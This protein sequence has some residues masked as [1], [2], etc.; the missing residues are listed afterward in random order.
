MKML[1]SALLLLLALAA[2]PLAAQPKLAP[3]PPEAQQAIQSALQ[4]AQGGDLAGAIALL[5]PLRKPGAHPAVLSLLGSLYLEAG[6]SREALALL[7]PIA[8]T[9]AAGPLILHNAARAALAEGQTDLAKKYLRHAVR[10]A[11]GSPAARD[12]GLLLG[13]DG[14]IAESYSLL[15]P[16]ALAH[17]DDP[18]TRLAAAFAAVELQ[19]AA[20]GEELLKGLPQDSPRVQLLHARLLALE[21]APQ[22]AIALLEPLAKSGPPE[23]LPEVRRNL[24]RL[25]L[26]TGDSKRAVAFLQGNVGDDPALAVLLG[27]AQYRAGDPEAAIQVLAPFAKAALAAGDPTAPGDRA[28]A[29]ELEL[30]YGQALVATS[31]WNEAIQALDRSAKL[32]PEVLEA[33]QLLGRAQ[34]AA[35]QREAA[36]KSMARVKELQEKKPKG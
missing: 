27:R 30:E 3:P 17:P 4:K 34:L 13:S 23:L 8:E 14:Q 25:Y 12:L 24:A 2:A 26:G 35:G 31:R 20:E 36:E 5:E 6:R 21:N 32:N 28:A 11:P 7:Q 10:M 19:R 18:D 1:S 33:W 15:R 22:G 16:W 29:A 9:A